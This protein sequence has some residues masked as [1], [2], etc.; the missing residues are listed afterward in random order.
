MDRRISSAEYPIELKKGELLRGEVKADGPVNV[1]LLTKYTLN[2]FKE[3][4]DY[5]PGYVDGDEGV[6]RTT[7]NFTAPSDGTWFLVVE[8]AAKDTVQ[9]DVKLAASRSD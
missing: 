8:N 5:E 3:E 1:Y 7:I 2:R 4:D 9:V 6:L